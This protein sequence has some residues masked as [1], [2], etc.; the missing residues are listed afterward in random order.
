[1]KGIGEKKCRKSRKMMDKIV[2][3]RKMIGK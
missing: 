1:M 2:K 3:Y